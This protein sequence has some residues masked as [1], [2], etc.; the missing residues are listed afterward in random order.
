LAARTTFSKL[1]ALSVDHLIILGWRPEVFKPAVVILSIVIL[2][3]PGPTA[4][5]LRAEDDFPIAGTYTE[6]K[7]CAEADASVV[8]VK[9]TADDIDS[10]IM[11]LCTI[12]GRQ[13]E[14]N[15]IFVQVE[16]QGA[17]GA[18]MVGD[19]SFTM[20]PDSTLAFADQDNTYKAVL[21]KC[22]DR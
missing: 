8:R 1:Q 10:P 20:N 22:P 4:I 18:V 17:G 16:C 21:H 19:V 15:R 13:R 2:A 6:N 7:P 9:I 11:G 14:G 5:E 12:R 3:T